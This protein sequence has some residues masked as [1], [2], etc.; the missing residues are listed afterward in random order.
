MINRIPEVSDDNSCKQNASCAESDTAKFQA[1]QRHPEHT[2][3]CK[4]ADR[5]GDRLR[6]MQIEQPAHLFS[7][8]KVSKSCPRAIGLWSHRGGP[9]ANLR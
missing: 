8:A 9:E 3:K 2:N 1:A 4:R 7:D 5:V 6:A